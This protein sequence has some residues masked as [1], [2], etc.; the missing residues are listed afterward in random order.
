MHK[1]GNPNLLASYTAQEICRTEP[2]LTLT[3]N[4]ENIIHENKEM[5]NSIHLQILALLISTPHSKG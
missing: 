5:N 4:S 1:G 3:M 2:I